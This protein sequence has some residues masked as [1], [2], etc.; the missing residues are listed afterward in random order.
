MTNNMFFLL[1]ISFFLLLDFIM[2]QRKRTAAETAEK[3]ARKKRKVPAH[4]D[5]DCTEVCG[6]LE[7]CKTNLSNEYRIYHPQSWE[8]EKKQF[9]EETFGIKTNVCI[10]NKCNLN[11]SKGFANLKKGNV[12]KAPHK[13]KTEEKTECYLAAYDLCQQTSVHKTKPSD[14]TL[15]VASMQLH[16][17]NPEPQDELKLCKDHYRQWQEV[18]TKCP[19]CHRRFRNVAGRKTF[20]IPNVDAVKRFYEEVGET[21]KLSE[22]DR[23]CNACFND[24]RTLVRRMERDPTT[25][26]KLSTDQSLTE[27]ESRYQTLA[28][29]Q[30][31]MDN[32]A[33]NAIHHAILAAI[34]ALKLRQPFMLGD[35]YEKY[36]LALQK[37]HET[38]QV[39][40]TP[41]PAHQSTIFVKLLSS[42][43]VHM[44]YSTVKNHPSMGTMIWRSGDNVV[45]ML[46]RSLHQQ[47][48]ANKAPTPATSE[49]Q[50]LEEE[51]D[52]EIHLVKAADYLQR[53]LR[54]VAR[55]FIDKSHHQ[56][57]DKFNVEEL[58]KTIPP[59]LWNFLVILT[60]DDKGCK[61]RM[62]SM[63]GKSLLQHHYLPNDTSDNIR[64]RRIRNLFTT[65]HL[66]YTHN[67][68][69]SYPIHTLLGEAVHGLGGSERLM[70]ILNRLGIVSSIT[71]VREHELEKIYVKLMYGHSSTFTPGAFAVTSVDNIDIASPFATVKADGSARG[72]H[73]TSYQLVEPQPTRNLNTSSDYVNGQKPEEEPRRDIQIP[74][75][76]TVKT[77]DKLR[78]DR[79]PKAIHWEKQRHQRP[80]GN[81]DDF[82]KLVP[83]EE[84]ASQE[85]RSCLMAY[86][87]AKE[88]QPDHLVFPDINL[89]C[90]VPDSAPVEKSN[91]FYLGVLNEHADNIQTMRKVVE[92]IREE[93]L[94]PQNL[95]QLIV[96]G[97]GKTFE[98]LVR[99]KHE[100]SVE[101]QW[102]VPFP[103]D[104]H[105]LKN[106]Q[107]V[108]MKVFWHAGLC[109]LALSCHRGATLTAVVQCSNFRRTHDFL[110]LA[111]EAMLRVQLM[112]FLHHLE[113]AGQPHQWNTLIADVAA[114]L[115]EIKEVS[116]D[117]APQ[118]MAA[119]WTLMG[120][121]SFAEEF[122]R[123]RQ[124]MCQSSETYQ[125]WD[126]FIHRDGMVYVL[127]FV[128]V[129]TGNWQLRIAA[130]KMMAPLFHAFDRSTYMRLVPRHLGE[131]LG[132]DRSLLSHLAA[133]GFVASISGTPNRSVGHDENHEMMINKEIKMSTR[134]PVPSIMDRLALYLPE[135]A[136]AVQNLFA[137]VC[138]RSDGKSPMNIAE[139]KNMERKCRKFM[140][141][142]KETEI[143]MSSPPLRKELRTFSNV[144]AD[145]V[146]RLDMLR[147]YEVGMTAFK[148]HV[149]TRLLHQAV[150]VDA[151]HRKKQLKTFLPKKKRASKTS[152]AEKNK[153]LVN[154]CLRKMM[155]QSKN[156]GEPIPILGQF[157]SLPLA[158]ATPSGNM[159][160]GEK[161][162]STAA[163]RRR[164]SAAFTDTY[165][166]GWRPQCIIL[167]GMF[168]INSG[169]STSVRTFRDYTMHVL[170]SLVL[171]RF[172]AGVKE[173]HVVFDHPGRNGT[174]PKYLERQ[175]R[176]ASVADV[177]VDLPEIICPETALPKEL[178]SQWRDAML[179]NRSN[180]RKLVNFLSMD[181]LTAGQQLLEAGQKLITAGGY[182]GGLADMARGA[183]STGISNED[184]F[185]S[186]HEESDSRVWLHC[187][188]TSHN[189]VLIYSPDTDVYH[190][191]MTVLSD[192]GGRLKKDA[193]VQLSHVPDKHEYVSMKSFVVCL[194][195]DP[196]LDTIDKDFLPRIIQ[197]LFICSGSDY[198]SYFLHCGKSTFLNTFFQYA[199]FITGPSHT[200]TLQDA[201]LQSPDSLLAFYRL[202]GC[203]YFKRFRSV[204]PATVKSPEQLLQSFQE[205]GTTRE[206]HEKWLDCIRESSWEKVDSEDQ[207]MPSN[208]ALEYHWQRCCWVGELWQQADKQ[209]VTAPSLTD[210]GYSVSDDGTIGVVWDSAQN[211]E[212]V[213]DLVGELL[214]G[215][216][217]K[218][219]CKTKR[220]KCNKG[221]KKCGAGCE[222]TNCANPHNAG[223]EQEEPTVEN[224]DSDEEED[225]EEQDL[226]EQ[227]NYMM[228][229]L[230]PE[231]SIY[232]DDGEE[233]DEFTW[234]ENEV[235]LDEPYEED[236][237]SLL[238]A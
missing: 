140:D 143:G 60:E 155:V 178:T 4:P 16:V 65:C 47:R 237:E 201:S 124:M 15:F 66:A 135:R 76:I 104:W 177:D 160:H 197:T 187:L 170:T 75:H 92:L 120:K 14:W 181:L 39:P 163:F 132:M 220:C 49:P 111:W 108:L 233:E 97:D 211:Q 41:K 230:Q 7:G 43:D 172:R 148:S 90:P 185:T 121:S 58:V 228:M 125:L 222:C 12:A 2:S 46:H 147:F 229:S 9:A 173:V 212:S 95:R 45:E 85:I 89:M 88:C 123:F 38:Y 191:G 171:P 134:K 113:S 193:I 188:K 73:A 210:H 215:C 153:K 169:P 128:A 186:N 199:D 31:S 219:G 25:E 105:T 119:I 232:E 30:P 61:D 133:G 167:E 235:F 192:E 82:V 19:S 71:K 22:S 158:I 206:Q 6:G 115:Q 52:E 151:P 216:K 149:A 93:V 59:S 142:A 11:I 129:R 126:N 13:S 136:K 63:K 33:D 183:T 110:V 77:I 34:K 42:L 84:H 107:P 20:A 198:T 217:C 10:C 64:R 28:D 80:L 62:K 1:S 8:D 117:S 150:V 56:D 26:G 238:S 176:D 50:I 224:E 182:D 223:N 207:V 203:I 162:N 195:S 159:V 81:V 166:E 204:M 102:M 23:I 168:L 205:Q 44:R 29:T 161:S 213:A 101:L 165:P 3:P 69:C 114:H 53:V 145:A 35:I 103:G 234:D 27:L 57:F 67:D 189:P 72:I 209:L 175:R 141:V 190:I 180:K 156:S 194:R 109:E 144:D 100:Y 54:A 118:L 37:L 127:F 18:G 164:Y 208:K 214:H 196:D 231:D 98:H 139:L 154:R 55:S 202:V 78:E 21:W 122:E 36:K 218:T 87:L 32:I 131:V 112:A 94:V 74:K 68:T 130:L 236:N 51:D 137:E 79:E 83:E 174:S 146:Q 40:N 99:I 157:I 96:V 48:L 116:S 200:G 179:G 17:V 70:T 221:N 184:V 225:L 86:C 5:R 227:E 152:M 138:P 106:L 91:S 226:E 24:F